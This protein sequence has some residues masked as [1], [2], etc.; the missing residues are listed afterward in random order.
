MKK[1]T[2]SFHPRSEPHKQ[3]NFHITPLLCPTV[4]ER[5]NE[6]SLRGTRGKHLLNN[7]TMQTK[8]LGLLSIHQIVKIGKPHRLCQQLGSIHMAVGTQS[9]ETLISVANHTVPA[10]V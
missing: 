3:I 6:K 4:G 1:A 5:K 10:V 2:G 9:D 7:N 8:G